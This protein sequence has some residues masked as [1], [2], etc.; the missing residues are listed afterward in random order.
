MTF[1]DPHGDTNKHKYGNLLQ[2]DKMETGA[3]T[4]SGEILRSHSPMVVG[5]N[6]TRGSAETVP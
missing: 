5:Q 4:S 2:E 1:F 3:I 6:G